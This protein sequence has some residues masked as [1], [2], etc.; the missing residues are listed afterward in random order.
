MVTSAGGPTS[1]AAVSARA[2]ETPLPPPASYN[3]LILVVS[4]IQL[5]MT[6]DFGTLSVIL[7]SIGRSLAVSPST[8]TWVAAANAV[9]YAGFLILGGRLAD[10]FGQK[11]CCIL[12][13]VL[14]GA[15]AALCASAGITPVLI[16]AR[17]LQGI[18]AAIAAPASFSLLNTALPEG[19]IRSRGYGVF[20][21]VQG[22]AL[23]LGSALGGGM[24]TLFGWRSAF[25]MVLPVVALAVALTWRFVPSSPPSGAGRKVDVAGAILVTLGAGLLVS[26]LSVMG[27]YGW[28]SPQA[29]A[30]CV[31][32]AAVFAVFFLL[33]ARLSHPLMPPSLFRHPNVLGANLATLLIMAAASAVFFLPNIYMQRV[34]N[35][36]ALQSGLGVMPQALTVIATG[37]LVAYSME[38]FSYRRI[39]IQ[40]SILLIAGLLLF[41]RI[42]AQGGYFINV[43]PALV[44]CACGSIMST[45]VLT[46]AATTSVPSSEQGV[47]SALAFTTQQIG[48]ALGVSLALTIVGASQAHGATLVESIH[49]GFFAAVAL[50]LAGLVGV[51]AFIRGA[52]DRCLRRK[53]RD[54]IA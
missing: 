16:G 48:L 25:L 12:G 6:S 49:Y 9:T 45:I 39:L 53:E 7:P 5:V 18:G 10:L 3:A 28:T 32:A 43:L 41:S 21:A 17:A 50:T 4:L 37:R 13:M 42:S 19:P 22:A 8:L 29:L 38:R 15:G 24:T 11:R 46:G 44:L 23:I 14:F 51:V 2:L 54:L 47:A 30:T 35:F 31:A 52:R 36:T 33:E 26:S 27:K 1:T 34:L 40:S 20:S